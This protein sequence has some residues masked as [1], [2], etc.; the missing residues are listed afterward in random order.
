VTPTFTPIPTDSFL[1]QEDFED[2][3]ANG[4]YFLHALDSV[5]KRDLEGNHYL[6][7]T[8][9]V[10]SNYYW[11]T[12][13]DKHLKWTDYAF[14]S[15]IKFVE[16]PH[17]LAI[18]VRTDSVGTFSSFL[19]YGGTFNFNEMNVQ[20]N[21]NKFYD[22]TQR[23]FDQGKWY[24]IRVQ[25]KGNI[26]SAYVDNV[27]LSEVELTNP[28]EQGGVGFGFDGGETL[29]FDDIRVWSLK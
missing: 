16:G 26:I 11:L 21:V 6:S 10:R 1:L 4:W 12:Y 25:I 29:N 17:N 22:P 28:L 14:E 13:G 20:D 27:Y 15:R 19:L 2:N 8:G 7:A 24:T 18:W 5:I 9:P 3:F 23:I